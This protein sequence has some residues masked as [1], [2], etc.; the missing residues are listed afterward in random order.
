MPTE[1]RLFKA[2]WN[3]TE[4]GRYLFDD[5][6]A[7]ATIAAYQRWGVDLAIDLEH[8]ML[9]SHAPSEPTARDARGWCRL[10]LRTDGSLWAVGVTWTLDGALRLAEKRQRYISPAFSV[11]PETSRIISIINVAIVAIPATHQTPA[12]VAASLRGAHALDPAL[13]SKALDALVDGNAEACMAILKGLIAEAAGG[14]P[15]EPEPTDPPLVSAAAVEAA[16][17]PAP[18]LVAASARLLRL[19]GAGS[20]VEALASVETYRASHLTLEK[21]R[22]ALE[23]ERA[24]LDGAERHRLCVDLVKLGGRAPASVWA[25]PKSTA[26]KKYLAAM[27]L[28]DFREYVA[29]AVKL[30]G[31]RRTEVKPPVTLSLVLSDREAALCASKK[32]D[33]AAYA[34]TKAKMGKV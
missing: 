21:T 1:F 10:E 9:A 34:A 32:I 11:D 31:G 17:V 29:D 6:A 14:V 12:L 3:D 22:Q 7:K 15:A 26:P 2:G 33:P 8:Q 30:G 4:N 27:P 23:A 18:E 13:V 28:D 20:V 19:T 25:D 5:V 24:V 16:P